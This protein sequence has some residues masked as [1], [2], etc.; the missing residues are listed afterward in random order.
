MARVAALT[1]AVVRNVCPGPWALG[2]EVLCTG[3]LARSVRMKCDKRAGAALSAG[4]SRHDIAMRNCQSRPRG[5]PGI[6]LTS[7]GVLPLEPD[8]P[9]QAI[10]IYDLPI[11]GPPRPRLKVVHDSTTFGEAG[12]PGA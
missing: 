2:A 11:G 6:R 5:G 1:G 10:A 7:I 8:E 12:E 3:G 4:L 9:V